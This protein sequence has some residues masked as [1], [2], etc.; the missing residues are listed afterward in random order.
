MPR[1]GK[2]RQ[3]DWDRFTG[4]NEDRQYS[5]E[6]RQWLY[7]MDCLARRLGRRPTDAEVFQAAL[8]LGYR[9]EREPVPFTK[10]ESKS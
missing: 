9:K 6:Q 2:R 3:R 5:E 10:P 7:A 8:D 1:K 4:A